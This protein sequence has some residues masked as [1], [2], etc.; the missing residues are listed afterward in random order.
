MTL[1]RNITSEQG[2][3]RL[4]CQR[5]LWDISP[6]HYY[7]DGAGKAMLPRTSIAAGV[8]L[9]TSLSEPW[10]VPGVLPRRPL[11]FISQLKALI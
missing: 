4:A 5:E 9:V 11:P 6:G 3:H 7:F 10:T 2:T 1:A 8:Q